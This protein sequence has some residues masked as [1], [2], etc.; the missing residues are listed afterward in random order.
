MML[1]FTKLFSKLTSKDEDDGHDVEWAVYTLKTEFGADPM[2]SQQAID[3]LDVLFN[4]AAESVPKAAVDRVLMDLTE[5]RNAFG[6]AG[7]GIN[8]DAY[9][10][11]IGT[12][13]RFVY[14]KE[15]I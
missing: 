3:A 11:A 7:F 10:D 4:L 5:K 2:I 12:I 1:D 8:A 15:E 6:A 14:K 13:E 9:N